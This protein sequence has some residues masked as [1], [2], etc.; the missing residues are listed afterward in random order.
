MVIT[1]HIGANTVEA[2][3]EM[4]MTAAKMI[5]AVLSGETPE[6]AVNEPVFE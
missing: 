5:D 2:N 6:F 4:A 3:R 1:P